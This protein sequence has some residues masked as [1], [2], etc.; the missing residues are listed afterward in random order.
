MDIPAS[1]T[2]DQLLLMWESQARGKANNS[3]V[4]LHG[5]R[6]ETGT[7]RLLTVKARLNTATG[8]YEGKAIYEHLAIAAEA[9]LVD[10]VSLELAKS[11]SE[12][13]PAAAVLDFDGTSDFVDLPDAASEPPTEGEQ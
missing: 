10:F 8:L 6:Y 7:L 5:N 9:D 4:E 1:F 2:K 13:D 11:A 12:A 3:P